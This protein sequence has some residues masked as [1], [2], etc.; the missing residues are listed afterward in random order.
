MRRAL[1]LLFV[2]CG[3]PAVLVEPGND[4][5]CDFSK[6]PGERDA[7]CSPGDV[8][9]VDN[10][11]QRY[12][13]E[14]P[15]FEG[16][17]TFPVFTAE[18]GAGTVL[19]PRLVKGLVD[20]VVKVPD[21]VF[22]HTADGFFQ[23]DRQGVTPLPLLS[24]ASPSDF[25][26]LIALERVGA[27]L[28]YQ[29]FARRRGPGDTEVVVSRQGPSPMLAPVSVGPM[30]LRASRLRVLSSDRVGVVGPLGYG[31]IQRGPNPTFEP[32]EVSPLQTQAL[33]VVPGPRFGGR[34]PVVLTSDGL[35]AQLADGGFRQVASLSFPPGV[36]DA[37]A[38]LDAQLSADESGTVLAIITSTPPRLLTFVASRGLADVEVS[39]PWDTC[40]PCEAAPRF[41]T[42]GL[43][44][45]GPYVDVLCAEG[46]TRVRGA[47][48]G[49][50]RCLEEPIEA[51]FD[52]TQLA[53]RAEPGRP[54]VIDRP[55]LSGFAAGG[56]NGQVW[57]GR[58]IGSATP[59]FMDRVPLDVGQVGAPDGGSQVFALTT[60]GLFDGRPDRGYLV[61]APDLTSRLVAIVN[62]GQGWTIGE[63][64]NLVKLVDV[65]RPTVAALFGP[66]LVDGRS[67]PVSRPLRGEAFVGLDGGL[68]SLLVAAD[69]S[70]YFLPAPTPT[71]AARQLG[72]LSPVL[73][74]E[75][76]SFIRSLALERAP[77]GS[78]GVDRMRGY[79]VTSR[80]VFEVRLAGAPLRWSASP[81]A[82]SGA[83]PV[84]VWFDNP[85][86]GLARV[87]Y[88]DGTVFSIPGGFQL[89]EPLPAADGGT[90]VAV[91]DYENLGGWPVALTDDGLFV[92]QYDALP[93]GRLDS[94]FPD[95]GVNKPMTWR[96]VTL[97]DGSRPWRDR[98]R[99]RFGAQPARLFVFAEP[100]TTVTTTAG[101]A[102]QRVFRLIVYLPTQVIEVGRHVRSN[103]SAL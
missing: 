33:D 25:E 56:Q 87:G 63:G 48:P 34:L 65:G 46:V 99:P 12:Q 79:V 85:R 14:G 28:P 58:T 17:P 88:R 59:L 81:L 100:T 73:T 76:S 15:Q 27:A 36:L 70:L 52:R 26:D 96:E 9:G 68:V 84:E 66:R 69:D 62:E 40:R 35:H 93:S 92:A 4:F 10:R 57:V 7:V 38:R 3:C 61:V 82:F 90:P 45:L 101:T 16:L 18:V 42:P 39:Q 94:R 89:T 67:E 74:P 75:P 43:D 20:A 31:V 77:T 2:L 50:G 53:E 103:I 5:P 95:G 72:D 102:Y 44:A 54:P 49:S 98:G 1:L 19:H 29:V 8:C 32:R 24:A 37:G 23:I 86:G 22:V 21:G 71:V 78:N 83:E 55:A 47:T 11:C 13:Y 64:G 80:S 51:P 41:A 60:A 97:P 30:P 6:P 91:L